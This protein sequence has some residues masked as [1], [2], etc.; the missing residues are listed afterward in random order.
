LYKCAYSYDIMMKCWQTRPI[1]RPGFGDLAEEL[2]NMLEESVKRVR[3]SNFTCSYNLNLCVDRTHKF[4]MLFNVIH[5]ISCWFSFAHD[6]K[7]ILNVTLICCIFFTCIIL[8]TSASDCCLFGLM[9][10]CVVRNL[11]YFKRRKNP[12]QVSDM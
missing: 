7:V 4:L 10:W 11:L 3:S 2:G 8:M 1:Q 9:Q 6:M 5:H 12:V